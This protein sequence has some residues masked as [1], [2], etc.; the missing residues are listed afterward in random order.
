[1]SIKLERYFCI[2]LVASLLLV[3]CTSKGFDWVWI[4]RF[5]MLAFFLV[6]FIAWR[7]RLVSGLLAVAFFYFAAQALLFS[8]VQVWT[9]DALS[10][11]LNLT[12][13]VGTKILTALRM[14]AGQSLVMLLLPA[15]IL[16]MIK[17]NK[18]FKS[19][20]YIP[21]ALGALVVAVGG[22]FMQSIYGGTPILINPSIA[23]TFVAIFV[24]GSGCPVV[25]LISVIA[26]ILFK[27]S[28]PLAILCIGMFWRFML[29]KKDF[30]KRWLVVL[31]LFILAALLFYSNDKLFHGGNGRYTLWAAALD[32]FNSHGT[33]YKYFGAGLGSTPI[34]VPLQQVVRGADISSSEF[35]MYLHNDWLQIYFEAGV[36]GFAL[37][38]NVFIEAVRLSYRDV[39]WQTMIIGYGV[40]MCTN[41]PLHSP[42]L[43]LTGFMLLG[44][45]YMEKYV[46]LGCVKHGK[47]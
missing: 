17:S 39:R 43:A 23:G 10:L 8:Q 45:A 40:A 9:V 30:K 47:L 33:L 28:T 27:A 44:G 35:A 21:L 3:K 11:P 18:F 38:V 12:A 34:L 32:W 25:W 29:V 20:L 22:F 31:A 5:T 24:L 15:F 19:S 46:A 6:G 14:S 36:I 1:M 2:L 41:F 13:T 42:I 4:H 7:V 26:L 16:G 37:A